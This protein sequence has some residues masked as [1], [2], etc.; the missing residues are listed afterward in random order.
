MSRAKRYTIFLEGE[1]PDGRQCGLELSL[2]AIGIS[3]M[4]LDSSWMQQLHN[5]AE[6]VQIMLGVEARVSS[7]N[8]RVDVLSR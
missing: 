8:A 1:K 4:N 3:D 5:F 6:S 2:T 7:L